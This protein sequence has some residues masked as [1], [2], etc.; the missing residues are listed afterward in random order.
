MAFIESFESLSLGATASTVR[1]VSFALDM[2][3]NSA[4]PN[5]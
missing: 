4:K 1:V 5:M 2:R 3:G